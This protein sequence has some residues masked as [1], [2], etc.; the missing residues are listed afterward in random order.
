MRILAV[1]NAYD[2]KD[3]I[4]RNLSSIYDYVD[5]IAITCVNH[6]TGAPCTNG[7]PDLIIQFMNEH[8]KEQKIK[9]ISPFLIDEMKLTN[10]YDRNQGLIKTILMDSLSPEDDDWIWIVEAD[11][12]YTKSALERLRSRYILEHKALNNDKHFLCVNA[13]IFVY[14]LNFFTFAYHGRFFRYKKGSYFSTT[15]NFFHPT[16]TVY[17]DKFRWDIP[18]Q[19][20]VMYHL[21]FVR[22]SIRRLRSR[23]LYRHDKRGDDKVQWF[24]QVFMEYPRNKELALKIN[25]ETFGIDGFISSLQ[26]D[27]RYMQ[28]DPNMPEALKDLDID[29]WR[30]INESRRFM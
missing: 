30:M 4:I 26:G 16:G 2:E 28:N 10:S 13:M 5:G 12:F 1:M 11:E 3:F 27:L 24:D 6:K 22:G 9:F 8:D 7:T 17:D 19:Y 15:N 20:M 25:K 23:Y 21:K 18:S 14:N 29:L